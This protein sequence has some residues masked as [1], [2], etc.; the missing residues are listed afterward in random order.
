MT[1]EQAEEHAQALADEDS[2]HTYFAREGD[3]GWEVVRIAALP[4]KLGPTTTSTE[5]R[6]R[7]EAD[8]PRETI[9]RQIGPS[10]AGGLWAKR[11][12]AS[13]AIASHA[14]ASSARCSSGTPMPPEWL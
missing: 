9:I 1:K 3:E 4:G 12:S 13:R 8:D 11:R 10:G 5:A 7:P 2:E 6:P 14:S